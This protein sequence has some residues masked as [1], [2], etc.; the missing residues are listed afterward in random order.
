[1]TA[2]K[3]SILIIINIHTCN[4]DAFEEKKAKIFAYQINICVQKVITII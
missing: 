1:M 3:L 4:G 2:S